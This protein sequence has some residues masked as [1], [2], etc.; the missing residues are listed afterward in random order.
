MLKQNVRLSAPFLV[1]CFALSSMIFVTSRFSARVLERTCSA[2]EGRRVAALLVCGG[3]SWAFQ[4]AKSQEKV[5][6]TETMEK[7]MKNV[8]GKKKKIEML[9]LEIR[10]EITA[11]ETLHALRRLAEVSRLTRGVVV[12]ICDIHYVKLVMD[13]AKRLNML[14]GHFFWLWID[15]SKDIDIFHN[16]ANRTQ[17]NEDNDQE[18]DNLMNKETVQLNDR[19]KR[20]NVD[21]NNMI[22]NVKHLDTKIRKDGEIL[23]TKLY[24]DEVNVQ[25]TPNN[26]MS[27]VRNQILEREMRVINQESTDIKDKV[28]LAS[29]ISD[30]LLNPTVQSY[31]MHTVRDAIEKRSDRIKMMK[32][33]DIFDDDKE[34]RENYDNITVIMNSL[35][36]GLLA[37]HPQPV[38]I[39]E[40]FVR[41]SVRLIVGALRR[42]L[43]ACDAWSAQAQ[44]FSDATASCWDEPSDAAA[45]FSME[46]V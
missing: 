37:L 3:F 27:E 30:F 28:S 34:D 19:G 22:Y 11:R 29:D 33:N 9:P 21:N 44:F 24:H 7:T 26:D 43:H 13:Q 20:D 25:N 1:D 15:A 10:L 2:L 8:R 14:E 45:D 41:A 18:I 35:P 12:L 32:V 38:K 5:G 40:T 16:I 42:V 23:D 4:H 31:K 46:F 6:E 36:I 39:D 17:F